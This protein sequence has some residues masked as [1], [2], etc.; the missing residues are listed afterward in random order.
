MQSSLRLSLYLCDK[1]DARVEH[2][3]HLSPFSSY[4]E[5]VKDVVV[6]LRHVHC[7]LEKIQE[8]GGGHD[9][10]AVHHGVVGLVW[11]AERNKTVVADGH[12]N[13]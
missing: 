8:D 1:S 13:L 9:G 10:P 5:E 4:F 2:L 7:W 3:Q 12:Q 11:K 6:L